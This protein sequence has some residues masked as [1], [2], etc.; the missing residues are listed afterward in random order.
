M[1]VRAGKMSARVSCNN[2]QGPTVINTLVTD[3]LE[4]MDCGVVQAVEMVG[5]GA[6]ASVEGQY[7]GRLNNCLSPTLSLPSH[8]Y[9]TVSLH[10]QADLLH[11]EAGLSEQ[12]RE[13]QGMYHNLSSKHLLLLT[14]CLLQSHRFAKAFNSNHE[15]R[16]LL[17]KAGFKGS[18]KPNLLKQETQSLACVLRILFKMCSDEARRDAWPLIQQRLILV[19]REALE[20]F[21]CL[22]SE[23]HRDAWTCL[24]LLM[25]TRIFK[26]SDERFA[27]HTSSYYP[28]LCEIMCFDLKAELR[29]VMR[30]F[31]LRIGPV[32]NISR[33]V[34]S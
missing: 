23:A 6:C 25:L 2:C 12:Q 27:A 31:F 4:N 28:L 24:L 10:F 13:E 26:M 17:W 7:K 5:G 33:S 19:C 34:I 30:R 32:F 8:Q 21:L 29:S 3:S 15:Q 9:L 14:D 11:T 18:V 1:W 20:Y 16:N 22:Q